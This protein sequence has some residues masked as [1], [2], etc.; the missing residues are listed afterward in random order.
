MQYIELKRGSK[1]REE[2]YE[3][4]QLADYLSPINHSLK[5]DE[6]ILMMK[7]QNS[8]LN[9]SGTFKDDQCIFKCNETE[10]TFHI[11]IC[12]KINETSKKQR[13]Y[14]QFFRG[15]LQTKLEIFSLIRD[16]LRKR[17]ELLDK[18]QNLTDRSGIKRKR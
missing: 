7:M 15:D 8:M 18:M 1:G 2:V 3:S 14:S 5:K 9:L 12:P 17:E 16:N 10:N 4:I 6:K 13:D 11:Y